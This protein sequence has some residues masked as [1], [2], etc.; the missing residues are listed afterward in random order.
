MLFFNII[1]FMLCGQ[2]INRIEEE[3]V[4]K[5]PTKQPFQESMINAEVLFSAEI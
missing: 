2:K 1:T 5:K 4:V 3:M